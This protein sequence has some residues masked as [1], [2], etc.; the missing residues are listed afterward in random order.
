MKKFFVICL[1]LM[2]L[3]SNAMAATWLEGLGPQKPYTGTPEVDFTETIGYMM[4]SPINGSNVR[5]GTVTLGIYFPREDVEIGEGFLYLH[6][7][8]DGPVMEIEINEHIMTRRA[9]TE[10]E[11]EARLWGCGTVFEVEVGEPLLANRHYVVQMTEGCIVS[12]VNDVVSPAIAGRDSWTFD[13]IALSYAD[14]LVCTRP[15]EGGEPVVVEDVQVGD[16]AN[17]QVVIGEN[18]VAAA[19]YCTSGT[20]Q[21]VQSYFTE[22]TAAAVSFMEAGEVVW[23]VVFLDANGN[24]VDSTEFV[25][26][27]GEKAE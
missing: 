19:L 26:V 10:E 5:T 27:V 20:F 11:L 7:E 18:A 25:T 12:A 8:E 16:T 4:L 22:S 1:A 6:T 24:A 13:T 15:V 9:M 17:F 3:C 21:Y 23:G 14:Q 2:M